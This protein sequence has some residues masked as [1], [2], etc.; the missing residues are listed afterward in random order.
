MGTMTLDQ[1]IL[2][3]GFLERVGLRGPQFARMTAREAVYWV[4]RINPYMPI[5]E[6]W[7]QRKLVRTRRYIP[8]RF[9]TPTV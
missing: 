1:K 3:K 7:T 6:L 5:K 8:V 4:S 9:R 2:I